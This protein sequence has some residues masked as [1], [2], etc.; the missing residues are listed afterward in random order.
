VAPRSAAALIAP[1]VGPA[2]AI[3]A[4]D[5][6]TRLA[7]QV[8]VLRADTDTAATDFPNLAARQLLRK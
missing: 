3:P 4:V 7:R 1:A 2:A 6:H 8:R 5:M